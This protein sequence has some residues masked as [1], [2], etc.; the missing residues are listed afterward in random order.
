MLDMDQ[1]VVRVPV[2]LCV[3]GCLFMLELVC[4]TI[5]W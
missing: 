3:C 4:Y 2:S 1:M 5:Y